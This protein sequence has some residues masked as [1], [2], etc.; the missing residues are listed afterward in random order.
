MSQ[1]NESNDPSE[2]TR[3]G[4]S[5]AAITSDALFKGQTEVLIHHGE[6]VY[7]LRV[8]KSGKLVLNK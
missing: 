1:T 4:K 2:V 6:D 5:Q 3:G 8:T 7:R